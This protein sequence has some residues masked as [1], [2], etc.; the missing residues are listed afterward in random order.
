QEN[1]ESLQLDLTDAEIAAI[2]VLGRPDGRHKDQ[3]PA[4]YEEF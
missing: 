3:D 1:L 2:T 4:V